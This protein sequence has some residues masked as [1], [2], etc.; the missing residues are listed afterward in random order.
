MRASVLIRPSSPPRRW[1]AA[2]WP[3][4]RPSAFF[5]PPAPWDALLCVGTAGRAAL[6]ALSPWGRKWDWRGEGKVLGPLLACSPRGGWMGGWVD[7]WVDGWAQA[8]RAPRIGAPGDENTAFLFVCFQEKALRSHGS[9]RWEPLRFCSS[10]C[11]CF[12]GCVKLS[13]LSPRRETPRVQH[14]FP[15]RSGDGRG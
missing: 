11:L 6:P 13:S 3:W 10:A 1:R 2:V 8:V 12:L 14:R 7:G 5:L 9:G 15:A 4:I